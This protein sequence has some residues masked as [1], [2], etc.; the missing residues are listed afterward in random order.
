MARKK[1]EI[2]KPDLS[3]PPTADDFFDALKQILTPTRKPTKGENRTPTSKEL[4]TKYRLSRRKPA[5]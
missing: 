4:N 2:E 3:S 5:A 1:Q